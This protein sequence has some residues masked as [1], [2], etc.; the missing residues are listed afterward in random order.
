MEEYQNLYV[1]SD[2]LQLS[3]VFED[4]RNTALKTFK[5]DSCYFVS[6]PGL[7]WGLC[8]KLINPN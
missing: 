3:D 5:L 2:T 6:T 7:A 1:T 4:F 8:K